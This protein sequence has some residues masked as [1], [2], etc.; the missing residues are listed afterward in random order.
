MFHKKNA[1][2]EHLLIMYINK[3]QKRSMSI[4]IAT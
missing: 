2:F 1:Y 3:N 4:K